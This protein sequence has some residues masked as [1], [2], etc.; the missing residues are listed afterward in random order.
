MKNIQDF[1]EETELQSKNSAKGA[2]FVFKKV[3]EDIITYD[4][5]KLKD[6]ILRMQPNCHKD[7]VTFCWGFGAYAKWLYEH[8]IVDSNILYEEVQKI[9]KNE[10]WELAKSNARRK[11]ISNEH[12]HLII[13]DIELYEEYN[14]LYYKT[15]FQ[16]TNRFFSYPLL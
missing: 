7:I 3:N 2:K 9:D 1:I 6:L 12:Y 14:S 13:E 8:N 11:F 4:V 15:L 5:H 10:L 16:C